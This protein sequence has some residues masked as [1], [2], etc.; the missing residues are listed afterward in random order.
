[1]TFVRRFRESKS[2][3]PCRRAALQSPDRR[4]RPRC[5]TSP[6]RRRKHDVANHSSARSAATPTDTEI[7]RLWRPHANLRNPFGVKGF[8]ITFTRVAACA[9]TL[10]YPT[11]ALRANSQRRESLRREVSKA[12]KSLQGPDPHISECDGAVEEGRRNAHRPTSDTQKC[13]SRPLAMGKHGG[14]KPLYRKECEGR[15]RPRRSYGPLGLVLHWD[16]GSIPR[17]ALRLP[18]GYRVTRLRRSDGRNRD[19]DCG[20]RE[21]QVIDSD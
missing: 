9:A 12:G 19:K 21:S 4:L 1:M 15:N 5:E 2:W 20:V 8:R 13:P 6:R 14:Q 17:A 10:G 16:A 3:S 7:V 18:L 11:Q